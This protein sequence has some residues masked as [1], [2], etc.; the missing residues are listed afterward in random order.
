[1]EGFTTSELCYVN[2]GAVISIAFFSLHQPTILGCEAWFAPSMTM[3]R[4]QF[5]EFLQNA[6]GTRFS[7]AA[8][9]ADEEEFFEIRTIDD[10]KSL[11]GGMPYESEPDDS[12]DHNISFLSIRTTTNTFFEVR[13]DFRTIVG[14]ED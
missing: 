7:Y 14:L 12:D 8:D 6:K 1:M 11:L 5:D 9:K 13:Q 3:P 4:N 2:S 10:V